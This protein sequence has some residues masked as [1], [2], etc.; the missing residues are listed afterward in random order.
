VNPYAY[1]DDATF[2]SK[3]AR[4]VEKL[5]RGTRQAVSV[6]ECGQGASW[7]LL[8]KRERVFGQGVRVRG[9]RSADG[10]QEVVVAMK[11]AH[12]ARLEPG[13]V[14]QIVES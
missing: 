13:H 10:V 8:E 3:L 5:A 6:T 4:V 1:S 11:E 12:L 2:R 9:N 14:D 7:H